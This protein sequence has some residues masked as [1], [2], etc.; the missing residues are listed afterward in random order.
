MEVLAG[1]GADDRRRIGVG[2][3][4]RQGDQL[5]LAGVLDQ[6]QLAQQQGVVAAAPPGAEGLAAAAVDVDE[7][8]DG[9]GGGV[10]GDV[11]A[12]GALDQDADAGGLGDAER[13]RLDQVRPTD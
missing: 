8:R 7:E 4:P 12:G 1:E 5:V 6:P 3:A 2:G 11:P 10:G 9:R 13:A